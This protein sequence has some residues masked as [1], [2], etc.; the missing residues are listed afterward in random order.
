MSFI[1]GPYT[2]TWNSLALGQAAEGYR[3]SH[4]FFKQLVTG[5]SY[6][7]APQ[8]EVYQGAE[9]FVQFRSIEYDAAGIATAMWPYGAYLTMG[10]VG[11]VSVQQSLAMA[12]VLTAV[13]GTPA[14]TAPA[15][16]TGTKALLAEG[17][18]VELAFEP[19]L[20]E[21]PI[22]MRLYPVA[23]VFGTAT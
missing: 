8:D 15:S 7:Q 14:A 2:A 3:V 11:R 4:S 5:D 13:A 19:A 1:A 20:R 22:R 6:A 17:F 21:V 9:M 18:P 23:G 16:L 12:L 10:Q